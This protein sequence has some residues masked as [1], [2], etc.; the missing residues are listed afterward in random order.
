MYQIIGKFPSTQK[1]IKIWPVYPPQRYSFDFI[2]KKFYKSTESRKF[3]KVSGENYF[4]ILCSSRLWKPFLFIIEKWY[5]IVIV[6][7]FFLKTPQ[8][9]IIARRQFTFESLVLPIGLCIYSATLKNIN[10]ISEKNQ[11][12]EE[13]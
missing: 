3:L 4:F 13:F 8:K 6:Y 7:F 5:E 12:S 1:L 2:G 10:Y 9:K 11:G